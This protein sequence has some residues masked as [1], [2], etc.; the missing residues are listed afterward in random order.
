VKIRVPPVVWEARRELDRRGFIAIPVRST[1]QIP[2]DI[3]AWDTRT[4]YAIA[5]R[6]SRT[7]VA[8]CDI[9]DKYKEVVTGLRCVRIPG[10]S[11]IQLWIHARNRF[12]VFEVLAG[13]LIRRNL[14]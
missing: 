10:I 6:R 5:V 11:E 12:M 13:G 4:I 7:D 8:I 1:S 2:L 9:T 14:P 3:I